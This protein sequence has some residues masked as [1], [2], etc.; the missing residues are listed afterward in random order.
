[1]ANSART[2]F[3]LLPGLAALLLSGC[4]GSPKLETE[5]ATSTCDAL[6]TAITSRRPQ[7]L[8]DSENRLKQLKNDG[9][10]SVEAFESLTEIIQQARSGDWQGAAEEL[11][12]L[13]RDQ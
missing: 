9:K 2:V 10:L 3:V 11:D 8:E 4:G 13:I 6:Y 5:E 7:L 1:M 12:G